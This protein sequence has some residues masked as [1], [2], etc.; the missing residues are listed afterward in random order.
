MKKSRTNKLIIDRK[1]LLIIV[2]IILSLIMAGIVIF[3]K[4]S[5][6]KDKPPIIDDD[7]DQ[8]VE[9]II[10]VTELLVNKGSLELEIGAAFQLEVVVKPDDATNKVVSFMSSNQG[11]ATVDTN[12]L[13]SAKKAGSCKVS[14]MSFSGDGVV[15]E[16][17]IKVKEKPVV[18]KQQGSVTYIQG[19]LVANKSY[20]LPSTYNPGLNGEAMTAFESMKKAAATEGINLF[21]VSGFRSYSHQAT[22]YKNYVSRSGQAEADRFSARPGHSEH[23]TGLAL[24][25]NSASSSFAGT[26]EAIWLANNSFRFGFIV[27]YPQGKEAITGYMYEPW[28][29]RYLGVANATKV[30]NS[31][32]C[33]EE[34]LKIDS[35]YK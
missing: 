25:L 23:Q 1:K 7:V 20:P 12:G 28:H 24:D 6:N 27:R 3:F 9:Q 31:G 19:I 26:K 15:V 32:M 4:V 34:Y 11:I 14:V 21:I 17:D 18:V 16:V 29:M 10:G 35:K 13:I 5:N 8:E 2:A 33:L 22:L 30:F